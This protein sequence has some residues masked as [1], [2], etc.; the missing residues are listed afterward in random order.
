MK[1]LHDQMSDFPRQ[2]KRPARESQTAKAEA[3]TQAQA[4]KTAIWQQ[5]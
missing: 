5:Q 4:L 1:G 2:N 3:V